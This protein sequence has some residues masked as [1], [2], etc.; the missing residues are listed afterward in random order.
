MLPIAL[1]SCYA[2]AQSEFEEVYGATF[3]GKPAAQLKDHFRTATPV[4]IT[5]T[6]HGSEIWSYAYP[7]RKP[8]NCT[9][10][11]EIKDGTVIAMTHKGPGCV[12]GPFN[13]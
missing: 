5:T 7:Y 4:S 8:Q 13:D 10:L 3:V 6:D 2:L 12:K 11:Y 9:I 1:T